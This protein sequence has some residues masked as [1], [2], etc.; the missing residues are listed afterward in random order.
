[1]ITFVLHAR[2]LDNVGVRLRDHLA[3]DIE[4]H[5]GLEQTDK[6]QSYAVR[7]PKQH[8]TSLCSVYVV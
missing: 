2:G 8:L 7:R 5:V 4:E 6:V 3:L 1:M